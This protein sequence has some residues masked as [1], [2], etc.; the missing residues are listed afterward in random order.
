MQTNMEFD[1]IIVNT[2]KDDGNRYM[3]S[4]MGFIISLKS[5]LH[6]LA[7]FFQPLGPGCHEDLLELAP[8]STLDRKTIDIDKKVEKL[9][10]DIYRGEVGP[11]GRALKM[12]LNSS[13]IIEGFEIHLPNE[14]H[15]IIYIDNEIQAD[16]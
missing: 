11:N 9:I 1:K 3:L 15:N 14:K 7:V 2:M 13:N 16:W 5:P 8:I 10:I 6:C 4:N 12:P